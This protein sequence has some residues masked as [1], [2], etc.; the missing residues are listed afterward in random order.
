MFGSVIF[1][2]IG[3]LTRWLLSGFTRSFDEVLQSKDPEMSLWNNSLNF[4]TGWITMI[5]LIITIGL[6]IDWFS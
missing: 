4:V 6:V 5:L 3:A 1:R 2:N